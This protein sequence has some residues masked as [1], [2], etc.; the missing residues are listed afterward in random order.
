MYIMDIY[1]ERLGFFRTM[2]NVS[3][4]VFVM[5]CCIR[6]CKMQIELK[7]R[8]FEFG[9]SLAKLSNIKNIIAVANKYYAA[10]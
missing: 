1:Q 2:R 10:A 3:R 4:L 8:P 7:D 6:E 5:R 9:E